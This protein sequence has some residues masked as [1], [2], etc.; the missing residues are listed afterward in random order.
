M[1]TTKPTTPFVARPWADLARAAE[2]ADWTAGR[3][4]VAD[5]AEL[6]DRFAGELERLPADQRQA[7]IDVATAAYALSRSEKA[8]TVAIHGSALT[9]PAVARD[10]DVIYVGNRA[11]AERAARAWA[12]ERGL[13]HLPLD[14]HESSGRGITVPCV[15]GVAAPFEV[16]AGDAP[17][18]RREYTGLASLIRAPFSAEAAHA[19][20]TAGF[21]VRIA[22]VSPPRGDEWANYVDGPRSLASAVRHARAEGRWDALVALHPALYRCLAAVAEF[23]AGKIAAE[24]L[25]AIKG[26]GGGGAARG[27]V[28]VDAFLS[29]QFGGAGLDRP[30]INSTHAREG[31][32][33][34]RSF[35]ALTRSIVEGAPSERVPERYPSLPD[36]RA[37]ALCEVFS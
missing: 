28:Y 36:D 14:L 8:A 25:D 1:T 5:G 31:D 4:A 27:T 26:G 22:L 2:H 19:A 12:S 33:C 17:V 9:S 29:P 23:G 34:W 6:A 30:L 7:A 20:I 3:S 21:R 13:G 24:T 15:P 32:P 35:D 37:R 11:M 16:I 10:V 18:E